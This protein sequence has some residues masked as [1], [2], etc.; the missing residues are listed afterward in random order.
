LF[1]FGLDNRESGAVSRDREPGSAGLAG[2]RV[3]G[4]GSFLVDHSLLFVFGLDS[5]ELVPS[6]AIRNLVP[7]VSLVFP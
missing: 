4:G 3:G 6:V 1:V 2:S 5:R 7:P